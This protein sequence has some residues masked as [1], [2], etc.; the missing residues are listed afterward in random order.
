MPQ[1]DS[2]GLRLHYVQE[3]DAYDPLEQRLAQEHLRVACLCESHSGISYKLQLE[4]TLPPRDYR[5]TFTDLTSIVAVS[6]DMLPVFADTHV[7]EIHLPTGYPV[8]PA[9]CY[10]V[11]PTWHPNIQSDEGPYQGRICGNTEGFGAFYSLDQLILRIQA[12]LKYEIYFAKMKFPYPEDEN[13]AQ[14]VREYAEPLGI[15]RPGIG[16]Q[17][18]NILPANWR[19]LVK[20]E[21]RIKIRI[22]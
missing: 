11:T 1:L 19:Q 13:V 6:A 17:E 3:R 22:E 20:T 5:I 14:W 21:K 10:M 12:M 16:I 7:L 9:I 15:V 8:A 2:Q 4:K 18:G